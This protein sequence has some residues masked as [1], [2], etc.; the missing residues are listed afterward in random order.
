MIHIP[1]SC[2]FPDSEMSSIAACAGSG[3]SVLAGAPADLWLTGEM[4]HH[5]LLDAAHAGKSVILCEH[6]NS[7]RGFLKVLAGKLSGELWAGREEGACP[8]IVVSKKDR[9]PVEIV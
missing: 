5:E 3:A 9:D 1:S 7:E 6:S 4:S 2:H 8:E